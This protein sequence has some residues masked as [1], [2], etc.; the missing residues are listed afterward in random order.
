LDGRIVRVRDDEILS[1]RQI[2]EFESNCNQ[3]VVGGMIYIVGHVEC[4]AEELIELCFLRLEEGI[5]LEML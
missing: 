4:A 5:V 3:I 2:I 1:D